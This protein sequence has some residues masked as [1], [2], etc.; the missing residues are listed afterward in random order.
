MTCAICGS[1]S[2]T[3]FIRMDSV[4]LVRCLVCGL[5]YNPDYYI[6]KDTYLES[7]FRRN[8]YVA[9]WDEFCT[10]FE[11]LLDKIIRFKRAG[12]LLDV[13]A[14]VGTLLSVAAR[15]GFI[16]HGVEV[17]EWA[18]AFAREEKGLDV[19]TGTLEDARLE[20]EAFDIVVINHVL[21]HVINPRALLAEVHRILKNDGLLVIGVPNIGSIMAGLRG[22]KWPSLRPKE[23]IWHFS[24]ATLKR[25]ATE[26][27]FAKLY[28][29]ARENYPVTGW[30]PKALLIRI[31]NG[32]A[33]LSGRSEAM[34]LFA[35]K[36][37]FWR[38]ERGLHNNT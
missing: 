28:F 15:S 26:A 2:S 13:G 35:M 32:M 27:G 25:L 37:A 3:E 8:E 30:G 11:S 9:R 14:G 20:T 22:G 29:E 21:E 34:L 5:V 17:S 33:V 4:E 7:Y 23:H 31:I 38:Y 16:V 18:S 24:P 1:S 10:M 6:R 36:K 19:L 12:T